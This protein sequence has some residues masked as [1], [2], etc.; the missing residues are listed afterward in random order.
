M[1]KVKPLEQIKANYRSGASVATERYKEG[2]RSSSDWKTK[3]TSSEAESLFAAKMQEAIANES[4]RKGLE[5]VSESEWKTKAENVGGARISQ[6][7]IASVDKMA[8]GYAPIRSAL[9][10]LTLP[11]RTA[12]PMSNIDARVKPVVRA[13]VEA[14]KSRLG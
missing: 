1:V 3:A 8:T 6:G 9:E 12:D 4:R 2:I 7:M 13:E 11:P 5:K 14:K 10:S